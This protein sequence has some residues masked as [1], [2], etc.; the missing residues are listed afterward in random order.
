M[1]NHVI[2]AWGKVEDG[3]NSLQRYEA[4]LHFLVQLIENL[5]NGGLIHYMRDM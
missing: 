2:I 4:L 5:D 1:K 3:S